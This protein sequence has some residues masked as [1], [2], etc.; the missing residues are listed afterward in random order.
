MRQLTP[1]L[2]LPCTLSPFPPPLSPPSPS[3]PQYLVYP[4]VWLSS[5]SAGLSAVAVA[6][7]AEA[8]LS[9]GTKLCRNRITQLLAT[10]AAVITVYYQSQW[11]FPTLI[12]AGVF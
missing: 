10:A 4:P 6:L 9:L 1:P 12:V 11:V 5:L 3:P 2:R 8:A 7:V